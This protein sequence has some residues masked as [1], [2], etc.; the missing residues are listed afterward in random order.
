MVKSFGDCKSVSSCGGFDIT[1]GNFIIRHFEK[2][3][4]PLAFDSYI[5]TQIPRI[6][7]VV[8]NNGDQS[9]LSEAPQISLS[10]LIEIDGL[11]NFNECHFLQNIANMYVTPCKVRHLILVILQTSIM[12]LRGTC[13]FFLS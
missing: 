9:G 10:T 11:I 13:F 3:R 5:S 2:I 7:S 6:H 8:I 1:D 12:A 4:V